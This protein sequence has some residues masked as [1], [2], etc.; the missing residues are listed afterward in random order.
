MP[1]LAAMARRRGRPSASAP[2]ST[3]STASGVEMTRPR[4]ATGAGRCARPPRP[5]SLVNESASAGA[6]AEL[7]CRTWPALEFPGAL[8]ASAGTGL[9]SAAAKAV[10]MSGGHT[11]TVICESIYL[12]T[13]VPVNASRQHMTVVSSNLR[14]VQ[15]PSSGEMWTSACF[16]VVVLGMDG[17]GPWSFRPGAFSGYRNPNRVNGLQPGDAER[18]LLRPT[19][20]THRVDCR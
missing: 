5:S 13:G 17:A 19:T 4:F 11:W 15:R 2:L 7:R 16:C 20:T 3:A 10:A 8:R 18:C 9:P 12:A 1:Q 14:S 6:P